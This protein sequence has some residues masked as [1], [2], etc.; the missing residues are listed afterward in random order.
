MSTDRRMRDRVLRRELHSS[1]SGLAIPLA[2]LAIVALAW[3]G[4]ESVLAALG[5]PALLLS[6]TA[7]ATGIR[8]LPS[9]QSGLL[10]A[11]GAVSAVLGLV[12][13]AAALTAGRRGRHIIPAGR[14]AAVVDDE[15]I[16]SALVRRAAAV[17]GVSPDRAVADVGRRSATVRIVPISGIAIDRAAVDRAVA[18]AADGFGVSPSIRTRV[19]IDKKGKVGG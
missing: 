3:L 19:V 18:E 14:T 11:A 15:V 4:T 6:P 13:V 8:G 17:A 7:M 16:G 10:V 12:L 2:V 9:V 5:R 1:R